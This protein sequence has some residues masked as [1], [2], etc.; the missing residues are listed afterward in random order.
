[1]Q[2]IFYID[3]Q[4]ICNRFV[5]PI[6]CCEKK[7]SFLISKNQKVKFFILDFKTLFSDFG[8]MTWKLY[9]YKTKN[10]IIV[11]NLSLTNIAIFYLPQKKFSI[12]VA[13]Q[14][15]MSHHFLN[16]FFLQNSVK[17]SKL[18]SVCHRM[19]N[20]AMNFLPVQNHNHPKRINKML[21]E[22]IIFI[23]VVFFNDKDLLQILL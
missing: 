1:M 23:K 16:C 19:Q 7:V 6:P 3:S 15:N 10:V 8:I 2:K 4:T 22:I 20:F 12:N 14:K 13:L 5:N 11:E 9:I 17:N 21:S 18:E